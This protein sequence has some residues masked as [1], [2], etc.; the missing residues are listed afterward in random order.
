MSHGRA[1]RGPVPGLGL[2]RAAT[3][4]GRGDG[5]G[6]GR[7]TRR[8]RLGRFHDRSMRYGERNLRCRSRTCSARPGTGPG[9][10]DAGHDVRDGQG[11]DGRRADSQ[12]GEPGAGLL[13][14]G[15]VN[16]AP[17]P[18]PAVGGGTHRAVLTRG[19]DGGRSP[20]RRGQ[21]R[22]GPAGQLELGVARRVSRGHLPVAVLGENGPVRGDEHGA[23]REITGRDGLRRQL[24]AAPQV[25]QVGR[26]DLWCHGY[27]PRWRVAGRDRR[28]CLP[29]GLR[30][31]RLVRVAVERIEHDGFRRRAGAAGRDRRGSGRSFP[32]RRGA[33][34][35]VTGDSVSRRAM[36]GTRPGTG[37]RW[38]VRELRQPGRPPRAARAW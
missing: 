19:V 27:S 23:E 9:H 22:R 2:P 4:R 28:E 14:R 35:S 20:F 13:R 34:G 38:L 32:H 12:L 1:E 29:G 30:V 15:H 16:D 31:T 6:T 24:H 17:Q 21:V 33:R 36:R 3:D 8:P 18:D 10:L 7:L 25:R 37:R 5:G 26:G 11:Q